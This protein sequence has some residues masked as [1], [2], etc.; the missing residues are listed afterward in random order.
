MH[1]R[2]LATPQFRQDPYPT[3]ARLRDEGPLVEV[4]ERRLM[5]GRYSVVDSLLSDRRV[6][7]DYLESIRLRYGNDAPQMRCSRE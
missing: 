2:D 5:S 4:A 3:Y 6:G 1:L 7:R